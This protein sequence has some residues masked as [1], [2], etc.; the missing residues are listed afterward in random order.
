MQPRGVEVVPTLPGECAE[1]LDGDAGR[2]GQERAGGLG[3]GIRREGVMRLAQPAAN[4]VDLFAREGARARRSEN[5]GEPRLG[6]WLEEPRVA[7]DERAHAHQPA[8]GGRTA[9]GDRLHEVLGRARP[10][11]LGEPRVA[12]L[13]P[14]P[15]L[16]LGGQSG[17]RGLQQ[18]R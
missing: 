7:R 10:A 11:L 18:A 17:S 12:E 14:R 5:L 3:E 1:P 4:R 6:R 15:V 8:R 2:E 9:A 13:A 16:D